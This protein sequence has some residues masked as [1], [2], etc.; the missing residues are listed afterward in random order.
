MS[1]SS[2]KMRFPILNSKRN[3]KDMGL[4]EKDAFPVTRLAFGC[5][6]F[7]TSVAVGSRQIFQTANAA[8]IK[9]VSEDVGWGDSSYPGARGRILPFVLAGKAWIFPRHGLWSS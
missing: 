2:K 7:Q 3:R 8:F 1:L 6:P 4:L 9:V 5:V